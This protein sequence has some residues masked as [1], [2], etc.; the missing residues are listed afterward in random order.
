M[1]QP[2][3]GSKSVATIPSDFPHPERLGDRDLFRAVLGSPARSTF[4]K[5]IS[6]RKIPQPRKVG[7]L[8]RWPETQMASVRDAGFA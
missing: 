8:N 5:W 2:L 4:A 6:D 1:I 3:S 7:S